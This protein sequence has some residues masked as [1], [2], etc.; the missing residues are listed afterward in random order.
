[1]P[2]RVAGKMGTAKSSP[3]KR[4]SPAMTATRWETFE[5]WCAMS[6]HD[7]GGTYVGELPS[8]MVQS[9]VENWFCTSISP[10]SVTIAGYASV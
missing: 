2:A 6:R 5:K 10:S 1:M 8:G 4:T 3:S 7:S 9:G